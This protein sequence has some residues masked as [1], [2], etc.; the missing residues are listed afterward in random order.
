MLSLGNNHNGKVFWPGVAILAGA[1]LAGGA[2]ADEANGFS[3]EHVSCRGEQHEIRIVVTGVKKSAGLITADL[4]PNKQDGF[5]L[6]RGRLKQVKFAARA[7][8]TKFCLTAP[9]AGD[10]AIALYQDKNANGHFDKNALG[11]PAEPWGLSNNPKVRLA[12]PPVEKTLFPVAES[13][14]NVEISLK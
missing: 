5:L 9:E 14:A 2:A 4:Y 13:G 6:G 7:P 10:F 11:L 3:F 8:V 1:I 12:P